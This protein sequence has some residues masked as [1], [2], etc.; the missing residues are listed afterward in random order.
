[1]NKVIYKQNTGVL[2]VNQNILKRSTI[3]YLVNEVIDES[4]EF[5]CCYSRC[6]GKYRFL[7]RVKEVGGILKLTPSTCSYK[8]K[9]FVNSSDVYKEDGSIVLDLSNMIVNDIAFELEIEKNQTILI[10]RI[11]NGQTNNLVIKVK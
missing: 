6:N 9:V 11:V 8:M 3:S 7:V 1:M 2:S 10:S 5:S 4:T